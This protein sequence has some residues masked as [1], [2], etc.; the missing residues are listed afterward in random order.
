MDLTNKLMVLHTSQ[1]ELANVG[2][3]HRDSV[4][5]HYGG[6]PQNDSPEK[7]GVTQEVK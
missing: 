1:I 3:Y 4:N 7:H 6:H 5:C 2:F